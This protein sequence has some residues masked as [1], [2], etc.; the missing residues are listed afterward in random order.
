MIQPGI[1]SAWY[2]F[3]MISTQ[4]FEDTIKT[5][6]VSIQC[7]TL[8]ELLILGI[9]LH[10][11]LQFLIDNPGFWSAVFNTQIRILC[12]PLLRGFANTSV[13]TV[14]LIRQQP[15]LSNQTS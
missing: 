13:N 7:R 15:K 11:H 10:L 4:T 2:F 14:S 3:V 8:T 9:F 6:V 1:P 5:N 12:E